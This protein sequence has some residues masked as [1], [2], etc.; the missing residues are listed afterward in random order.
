MA[1]KFLY[2]I[3]VLIV[4]VVAG[5]FAYRFFGNDIIR[6][7]MVPRTAFQAEGAL[8]P[9]DQTFG[10]IPAYTGTVGTDAS[11]APSVTDPDSS[12]AQPT[13][14]APTGTSPTP[15]TSQPSVQEPVT[16]EGQPAKYTDEPTMGI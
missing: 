13:Q 12:A 10:T 15:V 4:I 5:A 2:S 11:T 3:A 14:P 6:W 1:R 8:T 16:N 7:S 9:A